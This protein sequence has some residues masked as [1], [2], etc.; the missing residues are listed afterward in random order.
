MND[1]AVLINTNSNYHDA[2]KVCSKQLSKYL[3]GLIRY[4][5]TD[6]RLSL[7][8]QT[9]FLEYPKEIDFRSQ[10]LFCVRKIEEPISLTMNDDYFMVDHPNMLLLERYRKLLINSP[11]LSFIRLLRG[12]NFT[13]SKLTSLPLYKL[14]PL[15]PFYFSQVATLWKTRHLQLV[16]EMTP[17][18][19]IARKN[20]ELQAEV[21]SDQVCRRVGI[22]GLCHYDGEW[23]R[24]AHHYDSN[25]LPHISSAI[26]GG[27][28]NFKEYSMELEGILHHHG[29][30]RNDRGL[31]T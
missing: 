29:I 23:K 3:P 14:N 26:V 16:Y 19:G 22:W 2:L 12:F 1:V 21:L 11:R 25:V 18:S 15:M 8:E 17:R 13:R 5:F 30:D 20:R 24:G 10:F 27:K 9:I 31:L 28:W 6:E 7:A 4:V